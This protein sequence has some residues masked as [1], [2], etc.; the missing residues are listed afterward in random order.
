MKIKRMHD[1]VAVNPFELVIDMSLDS[2]NVEQKVLSLQDNGI[3]QPVTVWK[4][5]NR[6]I[7][8]FHRT[9]AARRL[10]WKTIL[11]TVINCDEEAF[12]DAR[13]QSA[14]QHH[15]ISNRRLSEWL[16]E[17]WKS[18][19][20]A[21]DAR[22]TDGILADYEKF[23]IDKKVSDK[24]REMLP[25][26]EWVYQHYQIGKHTV[27]T[28]GSGEILVGKSDSP[29]LMWMAAKAD[30]WG[31]DIWSACIDIIYRS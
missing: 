7:D 20:W 4:S 24:E 10:G 13:I 8:G 18:T 28:A 9:E 14:K 6:I 21:K 22:D 2:G 15:S 26:L 30:V 31:V 27:Y 1:V 16:F 17:L 19:E 3:I 5:G 29:E 11:C 25:F 12:W 23:G